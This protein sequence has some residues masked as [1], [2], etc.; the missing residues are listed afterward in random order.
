MHERR[1][2]QKNSEGIGA[3]APTSVR[4]WW[5]AW[6][7][8]QGNNG[9]IVRSPLNFSGMGLDSSFVLGSFALPI[10]V[11]CSAKSADFAFEQGS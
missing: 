2:T 10:K 5:R 9:R 3:H 7:R 8:G 6:G 1:E 4:Q 11:G